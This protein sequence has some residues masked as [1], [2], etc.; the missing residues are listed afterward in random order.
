MIHS[1]DFDLAPRIMLKFEWLHNFSITFYVNEKL[2][3]TD[4]RFIEFRCCCRNVASHLRTS[5]RGS[6]R[7]VRV[8]LFVWISFKSTS[9]RIRILEM[10]K[11]PKIPPWLRAQ[12]RPDQSPEVV[13]LRRDPSPPKKNSGLLINYSSSVIHFPDLWVWKTVKRVALVEICENH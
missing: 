13:P 10:S 2:I 3:V 4:S 1:K 12:K 5:L 8:D 9:V 6:L 7:R 11:M